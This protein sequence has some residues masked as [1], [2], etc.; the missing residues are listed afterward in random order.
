MNHRLKLQSLYL[1]CESGACLEWVCSKFQF[2]HGQ[3]PTDT[4]IQCGICYKADISFVGLLI[5]PKGTEDL[6]ESRNMMWKE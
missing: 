4:N 5:I 6:P 3:L 1:G 2:S